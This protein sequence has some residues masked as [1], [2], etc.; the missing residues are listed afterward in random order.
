MLIAT[1]VDPTTLTLW[2]CPGCG[3]Y[4]VLRADDARSLVKVAPRCERCSVRTERVER[5]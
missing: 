3:L 4:L 5:A 2:H 1:K